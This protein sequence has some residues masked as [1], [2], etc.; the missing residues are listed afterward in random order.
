MWSQVL[1]FWDVS[2]HPN[3]AARINNAHCAPNGAWRT[4]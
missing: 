1:L 2:I 4:P 3:I